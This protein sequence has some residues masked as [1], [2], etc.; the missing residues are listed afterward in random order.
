MHEA[1]WK[2]VSERAYLDVMQTSEAGLDMIARLEGE[3]LHVYK[4][5]VGILTVGIGHVVKPGESF[6]QGITREQS[7]QLLRD[8]VKVVEA[9]VNDCVKVPLTQDQFDSLVSFTFN[10]GTG[11]LRRSRLL[12]LLNAGDYLGAANE[13]PKWRKAGGRVLQGLVNRRQTERCVFLKTALDTPG[14]VDHG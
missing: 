9:A 8:D 14:D 13:F 11:N 2:S 6:S 1:C 5:A 12:R 4:D 10:V 7:R 3:V